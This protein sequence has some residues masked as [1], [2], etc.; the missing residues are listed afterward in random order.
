MPSSSKGHQEGIRWLRD[1][2][3]RFID[4]R[5]PRK[6]DPTLQFRGALSKHLDPP[7]LMVLRR[8]PNNP[9]SEIGHHEPGRSQ[10][11]EFLDES[12]PETSS[13]RARQYFGRPQVRS[14]SLPAKVRRQNVQAPKA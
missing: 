11:V 8:H 13:A 9:I 5:S 10:P 4:A 3:A 7:L 6:L 12:K 1:R 14:G 2:S